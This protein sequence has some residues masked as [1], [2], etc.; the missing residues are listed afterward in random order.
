MTPTDTILQA[1]WT[2]MRIESNRNPDG[3]TAF[4]KGNY[5]LF[6][7]TRHRYLPQ[8]FIEISVRDPVAHIDR[9]GDDRTI[10]FFSFIYT[11]EVIGHLDNLLF[12]NL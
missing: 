9:V 5:W 6:L 7:D 3:R 2:K 11:P 10:Y 8:D 12:P 1:G 4:E